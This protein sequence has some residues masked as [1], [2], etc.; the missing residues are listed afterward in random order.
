MSCSANQVSPVGNS[1]AVMARVHGL[2]QANI[3]VASVSTISRTIYVK[4]TGAVVQGP[5]T[6]TVGD[7][8][9][10]TLS[11]ANG[12]KQDTIGWNFNDEID[13]SL[14]DTAGKLVI[15]YTIQPINSGPPI[16]LKMPFTAESV[17]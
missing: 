1:L 7:V 16:V 9:T 15:A 2:N 13:G 17:P 4:E 5:D 6:L 10:D 14:I 8:V 3:T 12:W 11:T